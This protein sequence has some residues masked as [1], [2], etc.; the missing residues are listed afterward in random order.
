LFLFPSVLFC[1]ESADTV[2]EYPLID[3]EEATSSGS[4][5]YLKS[6]IGTNVLELEATSAKACESWV[7]SL[8]EAIAELTESSTGIPIVKRTKQSKAAKAKYFAQKDVEMS[9]RKEEAE[10]KK[11]KIMGG[12]KGG[13]GMKYVAI[14]LANRE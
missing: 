6:S 9:N 3:I 10:K 14:A 2:E 5:A 1:S 7:K 12:M 13:G 8:N 11:A 4:V